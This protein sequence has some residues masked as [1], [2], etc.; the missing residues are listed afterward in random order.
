M[1]CPAKI[2]RSVIPLFRIFRIYRKIIFC[3]YFHDQG[4]PIEGQNVNFKITM[5]KYNVKTIQI[6]LGSASYDFQCIS[7]TIFFIQGHSQCQKVNV[8]ST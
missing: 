1:I 2:A 6:A 5:Q 7:D 8:N 4:Q 3:Y